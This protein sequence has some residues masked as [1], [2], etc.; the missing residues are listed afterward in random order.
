MFFLYEE[1]GVMEMIGKEEEKKLGCV[2][3]GE[4][5]GGGV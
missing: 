2:G 3:L 4:G 1:G 5:E